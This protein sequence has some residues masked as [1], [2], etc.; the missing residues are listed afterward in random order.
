MKGKNGVHDEAEIPRFRQIILDDLRNAERTLA[1]VAAEGPDPER[2]R[3]LRAMR[4]AI[5]ELQAV[6]PRP[7]S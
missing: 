6:A 7:G 3:H 5:A 2:A 4:T 1:K